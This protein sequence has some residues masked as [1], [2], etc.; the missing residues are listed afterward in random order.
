MVKVM[1]KNRERNTQHVQTVG[2]GVGRRKFDVILNSLLS[3]LNRGQFEVIK[4]LGHRLRSRHYKTLTAVSGRNLYLISN[5]N[6]AALTLTM[7]SRY[8]QKKNNDITP[9][10]NEQKP[11]PEIKTFNTKISGDVTKNKN[12]SEFC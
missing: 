1:V 3:L 9:E 8:I 4:I 10:E 2:A 5:L 6:L 11:Q 7:L 12:V